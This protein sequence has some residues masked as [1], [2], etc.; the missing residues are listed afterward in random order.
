MG[1]IVMYSACASSTIPALATTKDNA[2]KIPG[3]FAGIDGIAYPTA[4]RWLKKTQIWTDVGAAGDKLTDLRIEDTDG[5][6]PE[7]MRELFPD[8]PVISHLMDEEVQSPGDAGLYIPP[9]AVLTIE[10]I[11]PL[12]A[13]GL[14]FIPSELYL[15]STFNSTALKTC[16]INYIWGKYIETI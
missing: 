7:G 6:I 2:L 1:K 10:P 13:R 11:D 3:T 5:K 9:N 4:G 14:Q 16:R 15:C 8:Y 12:D